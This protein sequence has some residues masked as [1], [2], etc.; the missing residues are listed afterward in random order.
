[1]VCEACGSPLHASRWSADE[2][3]KSCPSCSR[4]NGRFHVFHPYPG[5][6]GETLKRSSYLHPDG[7]QSHCAACRGAREPPAGIPCEDVGPLLG[8][9]QAHLR[10]G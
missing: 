7:P 2:S 5:A 9:R 10:L 4:V 6:F 8:S 1:M 3:M